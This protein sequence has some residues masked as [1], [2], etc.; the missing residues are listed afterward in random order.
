[1]AVRAEEID[2]QAILDAATLRLPALRLRE[3]DSVV[4]P[5]CSGHLH[6]HVEVRPSGDGSWALTLILSDGRAWYRTSEFEDDQAARG[7]A[8]VLAN[9]LAAIEDDTVE[10]DAENMTMPGGEEP[11]GLPEEEPIAPEEAELEEP[12]AEPPVPEPSP[13]DE[14]VVL[15]ELGPR[16]GL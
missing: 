9:L 16:L 3:A 4:E 5:A 13:V 7:L 12:P 8:S 2:T 15:F 11:V 14:A 10:P 6:A 1:M